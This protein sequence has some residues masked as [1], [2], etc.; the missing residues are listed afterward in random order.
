M[1]G[2]FMADVISDIGSY[3]GFSSD[4]RTL[5]PNYFGGKKR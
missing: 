1:V 4:F 3:S 5:V 2:T